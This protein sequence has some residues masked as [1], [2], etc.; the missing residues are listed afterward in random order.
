MKQNIMPCCYFGF[1]CFIC[2]SSKAIVSE[3]VP[4]ILLIKSNKPKAIRVLFLFS[5]YKSI[6][7]LLERMITK[8]NISRVVG[9][10]WFLQVWITMCFPMWL[11]SQNQLRNW[12]AMPTIPLYANPFKSNPPL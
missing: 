9:P 10:L 4:H 2:S 8:Q 6:F 7:L 11:S 5:L 1:V 3:Y 12:T